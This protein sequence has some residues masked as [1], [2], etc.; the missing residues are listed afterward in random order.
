MNEEAVKQLTREGCMVGK[1]AAEQLTEEDVEMISDLEATPMYVSRDMIEQIRERVSQK[2]VVGSSGF[3]SQELEQRSAGAATQPIPED[4]QGEPE[5]VEEEERDEEVGESE[6]Q[7]AETGETDISEMEGANADGGDPEKEDS[8][9]GD[10]EVE[11]VYRNTGNKFSASKTVVLKDDRGREEMDTKVEVMDEYEVSEDEK[12]VPEFLGYYNDRYER[13]KKLLMRRSE[14]QSATSIKRLERRSEGDEATTIG[15]VKDKYSTN[16]GKYIVTLEDKTG[17]FKALVDERDGRKIV[18]DEMLGVSGSMGGDIIYADSVVR[19]DLPIPDGV[20]TTKDEVKAAYISD[21]HIGSEDT[22]DDR[23]DRF[24]E[25]LNTSDASKIG[26][27]VMPGDVVEGVGV[28]PSQEDELVITS[29][30]KQYERFEDWVE[31]VPED[32]QVII[33]PG[34]HDITRLAEPQPPVSEE[35]LPRISDFNNVHLVSNPQTVRL[36]GIRSKGIKN[37]MYHGYS[38]DEH[39]D[40]IKE[41]REKAYDNPYHVMVDLLKRRHLAPSYGSNLLS[42]EEEDHLVI[43]EKPDIFVSGHLH[44][45]SVYSYKGVSVIAASTFQAQ[46]DF[47][48]RVGH[49]PDPGK[50]TIVNYKNR[51]T[52]VKQF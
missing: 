48:K 44:S 28:Y 39:I 11:D 47:Q 41:L 40:K 35:A 51:N 49:E 9:T 19:P 30:Y 32:I 3:Q 23:L 15:L 36:H 1:D 8:S 37:L 21:L 45:H 2:V 24:A 52:E 17:T 31:K 33:G 29:I 14:L 43:D 34:N 27:L 12:D 42:P 46:T 26:Y 6:A 18:Q 38:F 10:V 4:E 16:S 13:M 50:V 7:E 25:W 22:L 20:T 5:P